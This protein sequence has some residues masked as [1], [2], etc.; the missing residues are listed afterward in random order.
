M[1]LGCRKIVFLL[2]PFFLFGVLD[3]AAQMKVYGRVT[4][5][6]HGNALSSVF[7]SA[8]SGGK[9][10]GYSFSDIAGSFVLEADDN[11]HMLKLSLIGYETLTV[12][13]NEVALPLVLEMKQRKTMIS[14][15][16]V[17]AM[18]IEQKGDTISYNASAFKE[19]EDIVLKDIM[20]K[21]PGV[22]V[23]NTGAILHKGRYISKFYVEGLDLMGGRYGVV[24]SNLS[25]D[26]I[27]RK[28][29]IENHQPIKA[30]EGLE[31]TDKSA[32][33]IILKEN[34]KGAWLLSGDIALGLPRLPLFDSRVSLGR[35][36]KKSQDFFLVKGN[37]IGYDILTELIEFPYFG[38]TGTYLIPDNGF[39]MD[40]STVLSP[41]M[42]KISLPKQYWF[43][44]LSGVSS[45]NHLNK[46]GDE[47]LLKIS[48]QGALQKQLFK[49]VME[50]EVRFA[51]GTDMTIREDSS[52]DERISYLSLNAGYEY[53]S[54]KRYI[55]NLFSLSG[56][57]RNHS[58][59][60]NSVNPYT[61]KYS[62]PSLKVSNS[63]SMDVRRSANK[64]FKFC[65][66]TEFIRNV[67]AADF[68][69]DSDFMC[70]SVEMSILRNNLFS[71]FDRKSGRV[72]VEVSTGFLVD[73]L[74]L[75]S[76]AGGRD[77]NKVGLV[78]NDSLNALSFAPNIRFS[79]NFYLE[80]FRFIAELPAECK[81]IFNMNDGA[82][83]VPVVSPSVSVQRYLGQNWEFNAGLNYRMN[84]SG[85]ESLLRSAVLS[86]YRTITVADNLRMNRT[87]RG[88]L[89]LSYA[90]N[91][92]MFLADISA[93]YNN[94]RM[95]RT[96]SYWYYD[97]YTVQE[98][99]DVPSSI[100]SY[101]VSGNLSKYFGTKTFKFTFGGAYNIIDD[102]RLLQGALYDSWTHNARASFE[103][104]SSAV[105]WMTVEATLLYDYTCSKAVSDLIAHNMILEGGL[106]FRPISE[107][108]IY[109]DVYYGWWNSD[110]LDMN[111]EPLIVCGA[112]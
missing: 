55:E 66:E 7:V 102:S 2:F 15:A 10:V 90:D 27:S 73:L 23:T 62:L 103:I 92:N 45:F 5:K 14:S 41:R 3:A 109:G 33:N 106:V 98:W 43:D 36:A 34:A 9:A 93:A 88:R 50:E 111:N 77:V 74:S 46:L 59:F 30:L 91:V 22:A 60:L 107:I 110:G 44:N 32:V 104:S 54:S 35:F 101:G 6:E 29:I 72:N 79:S 112:K 52:M 64:A 51:D 12:D 16:V 83:V 18:V 42:P 58:S 65:N 78:L 19:K 86:D 68:I 75:D 80:K 48:V 49:S 1:S 11:P 89:S 105:N 63:F 24:N 17:S 67:H 108:S 53:N 76:D 31:V 95:N 38:R 56:Q 37:D 4:D 26:K 82:K 61:Q 71:T 28:E 87:L 25:A 20:I 81:F 47:S 40:F 57:V 13:I 8:Y 21:L 69:T 96:S 84:S 70:Q 99:I 100:S 39:D 85:T 94:V 97:E